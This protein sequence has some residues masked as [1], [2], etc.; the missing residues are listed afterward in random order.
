MYSRVPAVD[1][2]ASP[3]ESVASAA[4]HLLQNF[5]AQPNTVTSRQAASGR[6]GSNSASNKRAQEAAARRDAFSAQPPSASHPSLP[7]PYLS[8]QAG[9]VPEPPAQRAMSNGLV[10]EWPHGQLEGPGMP[11]ARN[12]FPQVPVVEGKGL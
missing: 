3:T 11:V 4:S 9:A 12:T 2:A 8:N 6:A 5:V 10:S 1:R 7:Q